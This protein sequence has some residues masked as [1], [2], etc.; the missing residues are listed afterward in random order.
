MYRK[1][2]QRPALS[3]CDF[4]VTL[5][6]VFFSSLSR[7]LCF[8]TLFGLPEPVPSIDAYY[9]IIIL[10][11]ILSW[12]NPNDLKKKKCFVMFWSVAIHCNAFVSLKLV[13]S[14]IWQ[15]L[16]QEMICKRRNKN[17]IIRK[18]CFLTLAKLYFQQALM[19]TNL[20]LINNGH[21]CLTPDLLQF[22][23][24]IYLCDITAVSSWL[25][26]TFL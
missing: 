26:K 11:I 16:S 9:P 10:L 15:D 19:S 25:L 7:V 4:K 8:L 20:R 3:C 21:V 2:G 1:E 5:K 6:V 22:T 14:L 23:P 13:D 18:N 17:I 24:P 12:W